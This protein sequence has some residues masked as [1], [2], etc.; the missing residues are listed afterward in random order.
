MEFDWSPEEQAFRE[1][2]SAF[3]DEHLPEEWKRFPVTRYVVTPEDKERTRAFA[4]ELG[5]RGWLTPHWPAEHGGSDMPP[6]HHVILGEE[7]WS[8][9]EPRGPQYMSVNWIG[10][11]IMEFGTEEQKSYHLPRISQGAAFWCQGFS[12]P[13]AGS[14]LASLRTSAVLD[15]DSYVINGQ[16][17][18][19]SHTPAAE[20]CFLLARTDPAAPKG[21]G[22]TVLL[23]PMDTPGIEVRL[24]PNMSSPAAFAEVFFTDVRVPV[25][26][27]LGPENGGWEVVRR[28]LQGERVGAPRWEH[29]ARVLDAVAERVRELG[30]LDDPYVL[31]KLGE[32]RAACEAARYIAYSVIDERA[33][34]VGP[35]AQTY[36]ARVAMVRADKVVAEVAFEVM[37]QAAVDLGALASRNY[38]SAVAGGVAGGSREVNLN[39]VARQV[40]ALPKE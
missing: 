20:W 4:R 24:I 1:G 8:V 9:G 16:K 5:K 19:T 7:M 6:W 37:G 2:L 26:S 28:V 18:W 32:A 22:I 33:R 40:L 38:F 29:A 31:E 34:G 12:E 39:L 27:R 21:K 10:P 13:D 14:D 35:S 15:G 23:V 3:V 25:S 11:A 17:I 30:R 36:V